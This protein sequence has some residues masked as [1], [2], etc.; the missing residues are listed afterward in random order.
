MSQDGDQ[1]PQYFF[2]TADGEEKTSS[3]DYT[4]FATATYPDGEIYEGDFI[5]G[6]REGNGIYR[7]ITGD[8][9]SG[10]WKEN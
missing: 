6:I 3:R 9:Y 10:Q 1:G 2:V 5:E 4:G 7:Y 8:V